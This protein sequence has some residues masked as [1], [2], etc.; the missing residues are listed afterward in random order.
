MDSDRQLLTRAIG[1]ISANG[2]TAMYDTVAEA[3]PLA[4]RDRIA[5][6]RCW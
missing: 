2:G 3:I 5:R 1:R 4:Q 6:R